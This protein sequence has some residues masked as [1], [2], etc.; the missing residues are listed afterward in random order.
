M[1]EQNGAP[2]NED[3]S[4]SLHLAKV[5]IKD[6]SFEAPNVPEI[7]EENTPAKIEVRLNLSHKEI[8]DTIHEVMLQ[9]TTT[10]NIEDQTVFL[11][12][13]QQAGLFVIT[14]M[15]PNQLQNVL[16]VYCPTAL[17]AY[18]RE[19]LGSLIAKGGFP[20]VLLTPLNFEMMYQ[21]TLQKKQEAAAVEAQDS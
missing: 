18:A 12:E 2:A 8:K 17:F 16:N 15:D 4:P 9:I 7:F 3:A 10:S 11:A 5:Y 13:V 6:A 1:A 19:A 20:Q 21:Q 14:G